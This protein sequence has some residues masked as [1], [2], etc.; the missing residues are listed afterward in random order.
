M[1]S[2]SAVGR[3]VQFDSASGQATFRV[4]PNAPAIKPFLL[5]VVVPHGLMDRV[6][7]EEQ[8]RLTGTLRDERLLIETI[9]PVEGHE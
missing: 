8:L 7:G 4:R 3:V 5:R 2:W 9:D 1:F 6:S